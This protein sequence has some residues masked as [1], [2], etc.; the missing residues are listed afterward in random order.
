MNLLLSKPTRSGS[1]KNEFLGIAAAV[2]F[3]QPAGAQ[4]S[5]SSPIDLPSAPSGFSR[6]SAIYGAPSVRPSVG[7]SVAATL[8]ASYDSNVTQGSDSSE[9]GAEGDYVISP[10][11]NLAY[12][13]EGDRF[14]VGGM[15][16]S[17]YDQYGEISEY[18]GLNYSLT[19]F[20][21]YNGGKIIATFMSGVIGDRGTN[22]YY[23]DFIEQTNF[24][25]R[26]LLRY[27]LSPKTALVGSLSQ[28][29]SV[30]ET[31]G[32][33]DTSSINASIAGLWSATPLLDIGPGF[34]YAL[35]TSDGGEDKTTIG[36]N[37]NLNYQL[38]TKVSLRSTAGINFVERGDEAS[39]SLNWSMILNYKASELWGMSLAL[40][41]DTQSNPSGGGL[42]EI[43]TYQVSYQRKIRRATLNLGVGYETRTEEGGDSEVATSQGFDYLSLDSSLTFPV[44]A[45]SADLT[46]SLRYRDLSADDSEDSWD[47]IQSGVGILWKF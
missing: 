38:S 11:V 6:A 28:R 37:L 42:D 32:Y 1:L 26:L 8:A 18:S 43:T 9:E 29:T 24:S 36:P 27:A 25:N 20:G 17:S 31:E 3:L 12:V 30:V 14:V 16:N 21:G 5:Q 40:L 15:L 41:R 34:R 2:F 46:F 10:G 44:F 45:E 35:R 39:D 47:G 19:G 33:A 13:T 23:G 4:Q 22:R 7:L